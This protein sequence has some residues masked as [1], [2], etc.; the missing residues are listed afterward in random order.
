MSV[1]MCCCSFPAPLVDCLRKSGHLLQKLLEKI[2]AC[3]AICFESTGRALKKA[4]E[5][6][7][8]KLRE[9][10]ISI[11]SFFFQNKKKQEKV[12]KVF[13]QKIQRVEAKSPPSSQFLSK[14]PQPVKPAQEIWV[15]PVENPKSTSEEILEPFKSM[16][17]DSNLSFLQQAIHLHHAFLSKKK[18]SELKKLESDEIEFIQLTGRWAV[19]ALLFKESIDNF[20]LLESVARNQ[21]TSLIREFKLLPEIEK[22]KIIYFTGFLETVDRSLVSKDKKTSAMLTEIENISFGLLSI[23]SFYLL[24]PQMEEDSDRPKT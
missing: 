16:K 23:S 5:Y 12:Q 1:R 14:N 8:T 21:L 15:P 19:R 2:A 11:C 24:I 17:W 3:A 9:L 7:Y 10:N 4:S 13:F 22:Q 18:L 6:S 20:P